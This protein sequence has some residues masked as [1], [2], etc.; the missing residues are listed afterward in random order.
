MLTPARR[1]PA[2][3]DSR[4][5]FAGQYGGDGGYKLKS[6]SAAAST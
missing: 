3:R 1:S 4:Q 6:G 5:Q 2:N